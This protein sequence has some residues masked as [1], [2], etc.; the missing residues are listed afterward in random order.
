MRYHTPYATAITNACPRVRID[1]AMLLQRTRRSGDAQFWFPQR[2]LVSSTNNRS[3][4]FMFY[5]IGHKKHWSNSSDKRVKNRVPK[6][7]TFGQIA[8]TKGS[9]LSL[10][11]P[12]VLSKKFSSNLSA[13][14]PPH[15]LPKVRRA[16]VAHRVQRV[17]EVHES[18][19]LRITSHCSLRSSF[20]FSSVFH[21]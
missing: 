11:V 4:K 1:I 14:L 20:A 5:R 9:L 13:H 19:F 16:F 15:I 10:L 6:T 8:V 12:D 7:I 3:T 18:Y 17:H 2:F 21:A